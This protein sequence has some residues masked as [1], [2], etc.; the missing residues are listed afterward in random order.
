M[1][2]QRNFAF[3]SD[4]SLEDRENFAWFEWL[5]NF[6]E[7]HPLTGYQELY[8][9]YVKIVLGEASG[10][11]ELDFHVKYLLEEKKVALKKILAFGKIKFLASDVLKETI[12]ESFP[13]E[14]WT[15]HDKITQK[16]LTKKIGTL[17]ITCEFLHKENQEYQIGFD[18][19]RY[20]VYDFIANMRKIDFSSIFEN[21][22][23]VWVDIKLR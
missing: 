17:V 18:I 21:P 13:T 16:I 6:L 3:M 1:S 10:M 12:Q 15:M 9:A 11:N 4:L 2:T 5:N 23:F 19:E 7:Q 20:G 22:F 14:A 8:A